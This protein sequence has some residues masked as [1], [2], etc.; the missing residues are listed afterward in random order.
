MVS[1]EA[2]FPRFQYRNRLS[3]TAQQPL[4]TSFC[5]RR[6]PQFLWHRHAMGCWYWYHAPGSARARY[7]CRLRKWYSRYPSP[8]PR[9]DH[10]IA[11]ASR[12]DPNMDDADPVH[13]SPARDSEDPALRH[14]TTEHQGDPLPFV[15]RPDV[16]RS[17]ERPEPHRPR[18][19]RG[20]RCCVCK[21]MR[22]RRTS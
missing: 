3:N 12:V 10:P 8:H 14:A 11:R 6:R 13:A 15:Q 16:P 19:A 7:C 5:R 4:L 9:L 2:C 1:A 17:T 20:Y 21:H 22:H 18:D